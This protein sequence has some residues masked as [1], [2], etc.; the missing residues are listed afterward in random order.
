MRSRDTMIDP[1]R[2]IALPPREIRQ[3]VSARDTILYALSIGEA[4]LRFVHKDGLGYKDRLRMLPTM[5]GSIA[6]PTG[7]W[8]DPDSVSASSEIVP[9]GSS[10]TLF[11][12]LPAEGEF[13]SRTRIDAVED[14]GAAKGAIVRQTRQI[15][16]GCGNMLAAVRTA[17]LLR[18]DGG[19]G[20]VGERHPAP[21]P[22]PTRSP[23]RTISF[24]TSADLPIFAWPTPEMADAH[25]SATI[26]LPEIQN[27]G[28][29]ALGVAGRAILASFCNKDPSRLC[30]IAGRFTRPVFAG[31]TVG[32][33][34]WREPS[35]VAFRARAMERNVLVLDQG[36]AK[37]A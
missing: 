23:D 24:A 33:E 9:V 29:C 21:P 10:I 30:R 16:D 1:Q 37:L 5:V 8:D 27:Q 28:L 36:F 34:L 26:G 2:L 7:L 14:K 18:G 20:N 32:I 31:E 6:S 11:G 3:R 4:G 35:H 12:Q 25:T 22:P 13:V 19:C 17:A 15:R